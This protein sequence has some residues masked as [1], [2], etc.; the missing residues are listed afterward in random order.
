MNIVTRN[1]AEAFKNL[2]LIF[3]LIG[4]VF[5]LS[6]FLISFVVWDST[7]LSELERQAR[8]Y[9]LSSVSA[10]DRI[11]HEI[12][13]LRGLNQIGIS[14][15]R[16]NRARERGRG[17]FDPATAEIGT[18]IHAIEAEIKS[19]RDLQAR[20]GGVEFERTAAR[21]TTSFQRI[22]DYAQ[23]RQLFL[24]QDANA[25][26]LLDLGT[27]ELKNTSLQLRKLHAIAYDRVRATIVNRQKTGARYFIGL[28]LLGFSLVGFIVFRLLGL[29]NRSINLQK[30]TEQ[31]LREN[32]TALQERVKELQISQQTLERQRKSLFQTAEELR[33]ARNEAESAN[34]SKSEFLA[35]MSHELRTPLNAIIGFS[36]VIGKESLGPINHDQYR[37]YANDITDSGHHLLKLINDILDLSKIESGLSEINEESLDVFI[38]MRSAI[39]LVEQRATQRNVEIVS[40]IDEDCPQ[41]RADERK[42]KQVLVNLL[43]NAAK[44]TDS[45]GRISVSATCNSETGHIITIADTG[46]GIA[47]ED[48]PK[49][50]SQFGQIDGTLSRTHDGT[51]LGLPLTKSLVESHEGSFELESTVGVGTTVTVRFPANRIVATAPENDAADTG[52]RDVG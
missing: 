41:L 35:N 27:I 29:I 2:S 38:M 45:G 24:P 30:K 33:A 18:S 9:H 3:L 21:L 6:V 48:I 22:A 4:S 28:L 13:E 14:P 17:R 12:F 49:A 11:E 15:I 5:V 37:E 10:L 42:I 51:G 31:D 7:R 20:Y 1:F 40:Q 44:F 52:Y 16:Q 25:I 23:R 19:V 47:P 26:R 8:D 39:K 43:S 32:Q 36:E 34:H 46:I 50:L